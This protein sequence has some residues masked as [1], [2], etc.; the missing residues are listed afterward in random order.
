MPISVSGVDATGKPFSENASTVTVSQYGAAIALKGTLVP[1]QDITISRLRTPTPREAECHVIGKI[2][3]Q[4]DLQVFSVTFLHPSVG[5]WDIYFPA[6]PADIETAG[7]TFVMCQTCGTRRIVHLNAQQLTAYEASRRLTYP[8]D[9]C[10][11]ST[12]WVEPKQEVRKSPAVKI[13]NPTRLAPTA[14]SAHRENRRK[15][16]R[17]AVRM[18]VCIRQAG[19]DDEVATTVD[20]S[21]GGLCFTSSRAYP[22]GSYIQ[23]AIPYSPTAVNIFV[24]ARVV[25]TRQMPSS[26][27]YRHGVMYL[28]ENA[29]SS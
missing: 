20:I 14:E 9:N 13:A 25:H 18:P 8:C 19:S 16:P 21:R 12:V 29:P 4:A 6:L 22:A 7:R 15:H 11:K 26:D 27:L 23:V 10:G 28:A 24:D 5:F 17:L 2:G 1:G 3:S